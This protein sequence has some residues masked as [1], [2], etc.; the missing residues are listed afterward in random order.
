MNE[1]KWARFL[2]DMLLALWAM[3]RALVVVLAARG[4]IGC[5]HFAR[6]AL[7]RLQRGLALDEDGVDAC[8]LEESQTLLDAGGIADQASIEAQIGL[9]GARLGRPVVRHDGAIHV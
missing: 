4:A 5:D 2:S 6:E 1:H 7:C 8:G 9:E 3:A